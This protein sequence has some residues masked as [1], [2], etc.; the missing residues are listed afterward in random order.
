[1]EYQISYINYPNVEKFVQY[2]ASQS[3]RTENLLYDSL[4][5]FFRSSSSKIKLHLDKNNF[6]IL[7]VN[8]HQKRISSQVNKLLSELR[9]ERVNAQNVKVFII[10]AQEYI[11]LIGRLPHLLELLKVDNEFDVIFAQSVIIQKEYGIL[12]NNLCNKNTLLVVDRDIANRVSEKSVLNGDWES[13]RYLQSFNCYMMKYMFRHKYSTK[14]PE[15]DMT[16]DEFL[17]LGST[18]D[19]SLITIEDYLIKVISRSIDRAKRTLVTRPEKCNILVMCS[20]D[21]S[22]EKRY[23]EKIIRKS[24]GNDIN[25]DVNTVVYHAGCDIGV[26][27]PPNIV[28]AKLENIT[29]E[30]P[31]FDIIISEFCHNTIVSYAIEQIKSFLRPGGALIIPEYKYAIEFRGFEKV[32]SDSE[33]F[34]VYLKDE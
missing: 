27:S 11:P 33:E 25:I 4:L 7:V 21:K 8:S 14:I 18:Y 31:G 26:E 12:V 23:F 10:E 1:M 17:E 2:V 34:D 28:R 16:I 5:S 3:F 24:I 13:C 20:T 15:I 32:A 19:L 22:I 6:N 30:G 9:K 29:F